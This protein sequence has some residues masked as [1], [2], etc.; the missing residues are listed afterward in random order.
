MS[1]RLQAT[2]LR[3]PWF[4]TLILLTT[5][6]LYADTSIDASINSDIDNSEGYDSASIDPVYRLSLSQLVNVNVYTAS[7]N[8]EPIINSPSIV[9]VYNS[10]EIDR[11]GYRSL[12]EVLDNTVGFYTID[13]SSFPEQ[14]ASRGIA[15]GMQPYLFLIDGHSINSVNNFGPF[16]I[17]SLP[18]IS[19]YQKIEIIRGPGSTLWGADAAMGIVNF[20][21]KTGKDID[22]VEVS[23]SGSSEDDQHSANVLFGHYGD[24]FDIM[25]S[26]SW[27]ESDGYGYDELAQ[28]GYDNYYRVV[29]N[30]PAADAKDRASNW[31]DWDPGW[32]FYTKATMGNFSLSLRSFEHS[33][34][35]AAGS[36][37]PNE[38]ELHWESD[39]IELAYQR[40]ISSSTEMTTK[41]F[42]DSLDQRRERSLVNLRI[43]SYKEDNIGLD[44]AFNTKQNDHDIRYGLKY[45]EAD[46]GPNER[47][48]NSATIDLAESGTDTTWSVYIEDHYNINDKLRLIAGGRYDDNNFRDDESAFLPRAGL[49]YQLG[50][51]WTAKY[52]YN[53]GYYRPSVGQ[54]KRTTITNAEDAQETQSHDIQFLYFA[55]DLSF[56]ATFFYLKLDNYISFLNSATLGN[57]FKNIADIESKGLELT[58]RKT[59]SDQVVLFSNYAYTEPKVDDYLNF[60]RS[61]LN[62]SGSDD[63]L[64]ASIEHMLDLGLDLFMGDSITGSVTGRYINNQQTRDRVNGVIVHDTLDSRTTINLNLRYEH[65]DKKL[66]FTASLFVKNLLD[67]EDEKALSIVS[68]GVS[69][70]RGRSIGAKLSYRF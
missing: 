41:L 20:I 59:L 9:T 35:E 56:D 23:V 21:P 44:I 70:S 14:I 34:L 2:L 43:D 37:G 27:F 61:T 17:N 66:P 26:L 12:S 69:Y 42:Y 7:K 22:G 33:V 60:D 5:A 38:Q 54:S 45:V 39:F 1:T 52:V 58:L 30:N 4:L 28:P 53:T 16:S 48:T 29:A 10:D 63:V 40:K 8:E 64:D 55:D 18:I 32:E 19:Q 47:M 11:R 6:P 24:D 36:N 31:Q 3:T 57:G 15:T 13:N 68:G 49:V 62:I 65:Q 51:G 25:A 46:S 50:G 67:D